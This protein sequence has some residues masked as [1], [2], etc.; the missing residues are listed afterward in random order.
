MDYSILRERLADM[1]AGC[2][3]ALKEMKD[4]DVLAEKTQ[5]D[6]LLRWIQLFESYGI[7]RHRLVA[8]PRLSSDLRV[9]DDNETDDRSQWRDLTRQDNDYFLDGGDFLLKAPRQ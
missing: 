3:E 6:S 8:L 4:P 2:I 9:V 1:R 5:I 7:D